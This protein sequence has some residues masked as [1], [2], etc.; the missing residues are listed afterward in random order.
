M[1]KLFL[2]SA[3]VLAGLTS[4]YAD[5]ADLSAAPAYK[6]S[7]AVMAPLYD[8]TGFYIGGH[9]SESWSHT[10]STTTNTVSGA[11]VDSGSENRSDFHGGGQVGYDYMMPSRFVIG[12]LADVSSG[13]SNSST[14]SNH[15]DSSK[16]DVSG[17][18]RGRLGY[19]FNN[20]LLYGTGGWAWSTG[21]VTRTQTGL[22]LTGT[23]VVGTVETINVQRNGWTI[24]TGLAWGFLPNWNVFGE[25]RYTN[26]GTNTLTFPI[27]QRSTSNSTT[28]NLIELGVN[29]K[30]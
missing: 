2:F 28:A 10:N 4:G 24:G 6:A 27:A 21:S 23:T 13:N 5:A 26:W 29:F 11:V 19:A 22:P 8:W 9:I 3:A 17:T 14:F 30:F 20:V 18:V 25:Y 1:K 12:I 16:T 15:S 7:P